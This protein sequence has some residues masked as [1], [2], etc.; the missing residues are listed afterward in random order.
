MACGAFEPDLDQVVALEVAAPDSLEQLDTLRPRARALDGHGDSVAATILWATLD[1]AL[2]TV[3]NETTGTMVGKQPGAGAARI[4][5]TA[6]NLRSNP[7]V[8]RVLAA[9][10]SLLPGGPKEDTVTVSAPDSLSDSLRVQ[11]ADTASGSLAGLG[12]RPVVWTVTQPTESGPVTL[13]TNDTAH[14]LV[15]MDTVV[16]NATGVA[17]V[18]VRLIAAPRPDSVVVTA[19]ARRAIG[20]TVP[21]SPVTFVV[22]FLP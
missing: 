7:I 22:R 1:T 21:G 5:A 20:T 10:D 11:L 8:V 16:T 18:R 13:V 2:L 3:V 9:A 4:Q 14:A 19:A 6:G 17:A 12:G 15:T